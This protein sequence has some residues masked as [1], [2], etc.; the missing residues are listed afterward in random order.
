MSFSKNIKKELSTVE[1]SICCKKAEC[2]GLLLFGRSF[3][4]FEMSILTQSA[5]VADLY[6][7]S[8]KELF[9]INAELTR[10]KAGKYTASVNDYSDRLKILNEF[11]YTGNEIAL[12]I[13]YANFE[14]ECCINAF[15]RGVFLSIGFITDPQKD[16]HLEF[17][18]P[19][20]KLSTDLLRIIEEL[21]IAPKQ[22]KRKSG[23]SLYIKDG[24]SIEDVL[25]FMGATNAFLYM[26]NVRA[27]KDMLNKINRV[28]NFETANLI[29]TINANLMQVD[30]I[31]TII[32]LSSLSA[33]GDELSLLSRLR[34]ENKEATLAE[35]GEMMTPSMSR[36][37]ISR[38]F[39]KIEEKALELKKAAS[40]NENIHNK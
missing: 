9:N 37:A 40:K 11:G 35:L 24:E 33:L 39:K 34:L 1:S 27:S 4:T 22:I 19:K 26:M 23:Y 12:R 38:R 15:L 14:N 30:N 32:Q 2:Y 31:N 6:V 13:N 5:E 3:S 17:I 36:S 10:S 20:H 25:G 16:Y 21:S 28:Y 18:T 7:R 8:I 29:R